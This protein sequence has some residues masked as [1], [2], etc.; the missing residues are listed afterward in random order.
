MVIISIECIDV[1]GN[2]I[3]GEKN[4]RLRARLPLSRSVLNFVAG[5]LAG[6]S[7]T[8]NLRAFYHNDMCSK[9]P[10]RAEGNH[11]QHFSASF[12]ES[13]TR[14][15]KT[16]ERSNNL[17]SAKHSSSGDKPAFP[18]P[19]I[20]NVVYGMGRLNRNDFARVFD[21]GYGIDESFRGNEDVL[22][23]YMSNHSMPTV[24]PQDSNKLVPLYDSVIHA[25]TNCDVMKVVL[26]DPRKP[27]TEHKQCLAIMGQWESYHV[28]KFARPKSS[29][30]SST[31]SSPQSSSA[32]AGVS[33]NAKKLPK[34]ALVRVPAR[35]LQIPTPE[36]TDVANQALSKY[37]AVYR[38]AQRRLKPILESMAHTRQEQGFRKE[39][40]PVIVMVAN[41]GHSQYLM[42]F[43][44]SA[45]AR[46]LDINRLLLFATDSD[47]YDLAQSMGIHVFY[48]PQVFQAIPSGA[49]VDYHDV[50]YGL[51][52]MSKG[53]LSRA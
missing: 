12:K 1:V 43:I 7:L 10:Q 30:K 26:L 29:L 6:V 34:K 35:R 4:R 19:T 5:L 27:G 3:S 22:M 37:L 42:N 28:H 33:A 40:D 15:R 41:S 44:C 45:R 17:S 13:K 36:Q 46:K 14:S 48:D 24:K 53:T 18:P 39:S 52:M 8:T 16:E 51:I 21:M 32:T 31:S 9:C 25:T 23:L 47:M 20:K 2:K 11:S 38:D 49:A 50:N